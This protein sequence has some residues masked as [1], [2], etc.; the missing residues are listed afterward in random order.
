MWIS[1]HQAALTRGGDK[2][3]KCQG[4]HRPHFTTGPC[5]VD[6]EPLHS[7]GSV[8][9]RAGS[10]TLKDTPEGYASA[11]LNNYAWCVFP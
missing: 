11:D 5:C 10:L 8:E 3:S 6:M 4:S 7:E 2:H 9:Q 1:S